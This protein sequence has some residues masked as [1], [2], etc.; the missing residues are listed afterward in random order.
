MP[1]RGILEV[2]CRNYLTSPTGTGMLYVAKQRNMPMPI[3]VLCANCQQPFYCYPSDVKNGR[4]YCS[5]ACRSGG[6]YQKPLP[7]AGRALVE[8]TCKE[9]AKPFTMMQTYLTAYRKKFERDP[10]FC[11]MSCSS[12][13][14][15]KAAD[16]R[17]KFK[18]LH[19]G[20][21]QHRNRITKGRIYRQQKFCDSKC[22][23]AY[24]SAQALARFERGEYKTHIKRHGYVWISIPV[25]GRT[26]RKHIM[27]HRYVMEKSLGRPLHK[28]ETVHHINGNRQ[29]NSPQNLELFSSRHGPGQRVVDKVAF[30][31]EILTLYPEFAAAAGYKLHPVH[32]ISA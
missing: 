17:N 28:D 16:E 1:G 8:F 20:T 15:R 31:I 22:K 19:C 26:G 32:H 23:V 18:C 25:L 3:E 4:K 13:N 10:L 5:Y 29:D 24:Q 7:A 2:L 6:R 30:A 27:E 11:S 9:C 12:T 14:L 21:E